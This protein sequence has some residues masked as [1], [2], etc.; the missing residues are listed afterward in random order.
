M[1]RY[2]YVQIKRFNLVVFSVNRVVC[3]DIIYL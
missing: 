1:L 2:F 3:L